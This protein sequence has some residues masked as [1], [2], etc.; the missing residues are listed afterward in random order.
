MTEIALLLK[1]IGLHDLNAS[2]LH[3][4]GTMSERFVSRGFV[5]RR[6]SSEHQDRIPTGRYVTDDFPVLS[7]GPTV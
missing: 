4:V 3:S 7:A 2:A 5:G 6:R 1:R